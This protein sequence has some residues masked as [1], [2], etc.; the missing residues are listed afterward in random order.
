MKPSNDLDTVLRDLYRDVADAP[1]PPHFWDTWPER[2]PRRR[3]RATWSLVA[4][5]AASVTVALV[6]GAVTWWALG[7]RP[8]STVTGG[9]TGVDT[10]KPAAPGSL[11]AAP[12]RLTARSS[13]SPSSSANATAARSPAPASTE[14]PAASPPDEIPAT[15]DG[16]P[17]LIG[18]V[19]DAH[20]AA[21]ADASPFLVGG[22][23]GWIIAHCFV[24]EDFPKSPL[25]VPC[26]DGT[27]LYPSDIAAL[28]F[29]GG[30]RVVLEGT[31]PAR[32]GLRWPGDRL[33]VLKVHVHDP[34][35]RACPG[36]YRERC[37]RAIVVDEL[38]WAPPESQVPTPVP[39][40][41][42]SPVDG[43]WPDGIP[44][45]VKSQKVLRGDTLRAY[46]LEVP[47]DTPFL[48][49]GS[50]GTGLDRCV[51]GPVLPDPFFK[52]CMRCDAGSLV[53]TSCSV[54]GSR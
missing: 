33:V 28:G 24:P 43:A 41:S 30:V 5:A 51:D 34:R 40:P 13:E 11:A 39:T 1:L 54:P 29:H 42:P 25:I 37:D 47:D 12:D 20:A 17:V 14:S 7:A 22:I 27:L 23:L 6:V 36:E 21:A 48:I 45:A 52:S 46:L 26:D 8:P 3:A 44:T 2:L 49:G 9:P 18:R 32:H 53:R 16:Q 31:P 35:A 38:V 10:T 15:V 50:A 4:A 19:M